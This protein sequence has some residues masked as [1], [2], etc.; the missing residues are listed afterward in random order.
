MD[1]ID[2]RNAAYRSV[3]LG[4]KQAEVL[5]FVRKFP[6]G[7]CN[8][9]ISD[10]LGWPVNSVTPRVLELRKL[11]ELKVYGSTISRTGRE[12][13]RWVAASNGGDTNGNT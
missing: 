4:R 12:A 11:G 9:E 3:Q 8:L 13:I 7:V 1:T 5:E 10:G 6:A 2:T